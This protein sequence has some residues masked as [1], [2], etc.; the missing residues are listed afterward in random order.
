VLAEYQSSRPWRREEV[1]MALVLTIREGSGLYVNDDKFT[2]S[3]I[4]SDEKVHLVR[5]RDKIMFEVTIFENTE[6]DDDVIIQLGDR[7]T[8]KVARLM[9]TA[10][11]S[12]ILATEE[13]YLAKKRGGVR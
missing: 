10:P 4:V 2:L 5:E 1:V 7:I 12:K 8:T 11:R 3:R 13:N 9:I 6:I